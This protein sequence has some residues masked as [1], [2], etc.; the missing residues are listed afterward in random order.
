MISKLYENMGLDRV[1]DISILYEVI[2]A[3]YTDEPFTHDQNIRYYKL[4]KI[5]WRSNVLLS[6]FTETSC[7]LNPYVNLMPL[8]LCLE[9]QKSL[10]KEK[11]IDFENEHS[12]IYWDGLMDNGD[13]KKH[14]KNAKKLITKY[15]KIAKEN[16]EAEKE[17]ALV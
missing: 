4:M 16:R 13:I 9:E 12:K 2:P 3:I 14:L 1:I 6:D 7:M 11:F 17:V 15:K 5:L 8:G 10:S